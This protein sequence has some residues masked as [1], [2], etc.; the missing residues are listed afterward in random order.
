M[1]VVVAELK[2]DINVSVVFV[3]V[4]E[5]NDVGVVHAPMYA[6]FTCHLFLCEQILRSLLIDDLAS[7]AAT[8]F[9]RHQLVALPKS[10]LNIASPTLPRTLPTDSR[11]LSPDA[12]AGHS[13]TDSSTSL[14][15]YCLLA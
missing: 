15:G 8:T 2:Q 5:A 12:P 14:V 1:Y 4:L 3:V 13:S 11:H 6:N 7:K 9:P 10:S